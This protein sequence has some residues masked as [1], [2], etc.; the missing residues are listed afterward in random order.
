MTRVGE[1]RAA[2]VVRAEPKDGRPV[3]HIEERG[4]DIALEGDSLLVA[5]GR[6]PNKAVETY[7]KENA[8]PVK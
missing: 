4:R 2:R 6:T 8:V 5:V 7:V 1:R 3:L